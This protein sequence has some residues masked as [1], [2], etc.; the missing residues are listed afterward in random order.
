MED[1]AERVRRTAEGKTAALFRAAAEIG[2][3]HVTDAPE[4][5]VPLSEFG[6]AI[7]MA[8]QAQD[9]LLDAVG[10][11]EVMGKPVHH[12]HTNG[13]VGWITSDVSRQTIDRVRGDVTTYTHAAL[14]ALR[15]LPQSAARD[16]LALLAQS[17]ER[18]VS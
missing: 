18:R 2:A 4:V 13:R 9:D 15:F 8:F 14:E 16:A 12:D 1:P 3:L 10:V 5:I 6:F 11:Q 7:G 17:L